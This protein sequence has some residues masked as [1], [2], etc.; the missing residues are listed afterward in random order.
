MKRPR[1]A[2][3]TLIEISIAVVLIVIVAT[4]AIASLRIGMRTMS[5]TESSAR[6]AAAI[7]EFREFTFK[8]SID[9]L[10]ARHLQ[11]YAPVLGDGSPMPDS[12]EISILVTI[13]AVDDYDPTLQ[14]TANESRTR[15]VQ[16]EAFYKGTEIQEALW[17]V[18]E[19]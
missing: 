4:S 8:D 10:D 9:T 3:F 2:G 17:L 16:V 12:N 13:T 1:N 19:H 7:R 18:A 14:V 5:G 11:S 15:V 6:A